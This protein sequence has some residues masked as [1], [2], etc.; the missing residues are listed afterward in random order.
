M[1][2]GGHISIPSA[3]HEADRAFFREILNL[4]VVDAGGGYLIFGLPPSE[5]AIHEG[6]DGSH[7]LHLMC[8][9]VEAFLERMSELGIATTPVQE[10]MWG[11]LTN[12]TL[13]GG[14]KLTVYEPT[15]KRPKQA[16]VRSAKKS[17]TTKKGGK[18][19]ARKARAKKRAKKR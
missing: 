7:M 9:D 3:N 8:A 15:H 1:I 13:P 5:V 17:K 6:G 18:K 19:P 16:A 4:P 2:V 11:L 10:Q 12:V 14:G